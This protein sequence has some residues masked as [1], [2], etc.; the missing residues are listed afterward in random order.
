MAIKWHRATYQMVADEILETK[1]EILQN[2]WTR[3]A[4]QHRYE[5]VMQLQDRF[6]RRFASDNP[7]FDRDKFENACRKG[8]FVMV[9]NEYS[10]TEQEITGIVFVRFRPHHQE[11][12]VCASDVTHEQ[13]VRYADIQTPEYQ[14][15]KSNDELVMISS[16]SI[17]V[18]EDHGHQY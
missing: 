1:T 11:M 2:G 6:A 8:L 14:N 5:H 18:P 3:V 7:K 16:A 4:E 10:E 12:M 15:Q 9:K 17:P 13:L